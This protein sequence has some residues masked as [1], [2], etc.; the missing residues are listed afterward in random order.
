LQPALD[1]ASEQRRKGYAREA[2]LLVLKYY[3]EELRYQKV[4]IS[5]HSNNE[6][7]LKLHEALGFK[8]EGIHRRTVFTEGRFYD[9]HW[10]GMTV[11]EFRQA[12][13]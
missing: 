9:N 1:I 13:P 12:Y 8:H 4:T 5:V 2:I 7:S 3:F 6:A 11:E 10:F